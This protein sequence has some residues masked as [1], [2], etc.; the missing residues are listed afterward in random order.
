MGGTKA[1]YQD[2]LKKDKKA[3][4]ERKRATRRTKRRIDKRNLPKSLDEI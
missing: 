1:A 2:M 4:A 3:W